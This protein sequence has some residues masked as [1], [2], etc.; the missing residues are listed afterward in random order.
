MTEENKLVCDDGGDVAIMGKHP[1][2]KKTRDAIGGVISSAKKQQARSPDPKM[3][4]G[5]A[6]RFSGGALFLGYNDL[7]GK[8]AG[9]LAILK[10]RDLKKKYVIHAEQVAINEMRHWLRGWGEPGAEYKPPPALLVSTLYPCEH[11]VGAILE[12]KNIESIFV[13]W[14][15]NFERS[16]V[17]RCLYTRGAWLVRLAPRLFNKYYIAWEQTN[18]FVLE[19]HG[20]KIFYY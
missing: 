18:R 7:P 10:N 14:P 12:E 9:D 17:G 8:M 15:S 19:T 13:P 2:D 3:K 6:I 4:V 20:I 1:I 11:C 16:K 5:A